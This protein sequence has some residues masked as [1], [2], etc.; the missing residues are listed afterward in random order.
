MTK[1]RLL[2]VLMFTSLLFLAGCTESEVTTDDDKKDEL[3]GEFSF[4]ITSSDYLNPIAEVT[5]SDSFEDG[6]YLVG[7]VSQEDY[8]VK[9]EEDLTK[10]AEYVIDCAEKGRV[11][12]GDVDFGVVDDRYVFSGVSE[13]LLTYWCPIE[14]EKDYVVVAFGVD[15]D[16]EITSNISNVMMT[17]TYESDDLILNVINTSTDNIQL[18]I[19]TRPSVGM[20]YLA[21]IPTAELEYSYSGDVELAISAAIAEHIGVLAG[22][23]DDKIIVDDAFVYEGDNLVNLGDWWRLDED[24]EYTIMACGITETGDKTTEVFSTTASTLPS[25]PKI[26]GVI[27]L[28]HIS[29]TPSTITVDV[30][31]P[32][33]MKGNNYIVAA[34]SATAYDEAMYS[35]AD[36]LADYITEDLVSGFF[37]FSTPDDVILF[38]D[39]EATITLDKMA[40]PYSTGGLD[41]AEGEE[42]VIA[43]FGVDEQGR[44]NTEVSV[45]YAY[46]TYNPEPEVTGSMSLTIDAVS[47]DNIFVTVEEVGAVNNY[48]VA[49]CPKYN[50]VNEYGEDID[51]LVENICQVQII[52]D[53]AVP[54]YARVFDES[55]KIALGGGWPINANTEYVVVTFGIARD[56]K[57]PTT[58]PAYDFV[59]TATPEPSDNI[60]TIECSDVESNS[61]T[62]KTTATNPED[63]YYLT[64]VPADKVEGKTDEE[65]YNAIVGPYGQMF[66]ATVYFQYGGLD[67][68]PLI[69]LYADTKYYAVAF[70]YE[71]GTY[72]SEM[73]LSE[74]FTTKAIEGE[75]DIPTAD[76]INL[77]TVAFGDITATENYY[78]PGNGD[79]KVF[80]GSCN[81]VMTPADNNVKYFAVFMKSEDMPE[82]DQEFIVEHYEALKQRCNLDGKVFMDEI[83]KEIIPEMTDTSG[84]TDE[85]YEAYLNRNYLL[86]KGVYSSNQGLSAG[87]EYTLCAFGINTE[88]LQPTTEV[89]RFEYSF[90]IE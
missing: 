29:S 65:I 85:E 17:T 69:D 72:T 7:V 51:K 89:K 58:L 57:E 82:S 88:T 67:E 21:P 4:E 32:E 79:P 53:I 6:N 87:V 43:A 52:D 30:V 34:Y 71:F 1:F 86:Y 31:R 61:V 41:L 90:T 24:F 28:E 55:A 38:S 18:S 62:L 27:E 45:V 12:S 33:S 75:T 47:V 14:A 8:A 23:G 56:T 46:T 80:M 5:P 76:E 42:Y 64:V 59:T 68:Y 35:W 15:V 37:D 13:V 10:I 9:Y 22:H 83:Q 50:F 25:V 2:F 77:S 54:D 16:G 40:T 49:A 70:V 84:L 3:V 73:F 74:P 63:P 81:V 26:E 66:S 36:A 78:D 60:I 44:F 19:T 11:D 20:Y 48:V 39:D